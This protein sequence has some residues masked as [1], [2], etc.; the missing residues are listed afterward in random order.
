MFLTFVKTF[1]MSR[2]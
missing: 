2:K 1:T